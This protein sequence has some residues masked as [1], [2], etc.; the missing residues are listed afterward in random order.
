[1]MTRKKKS[2]GSGIE[3]IGVLHVKEDGAVEL[4]EGVTFPWLSTEP[5]GV[6]IDE[7]GMRVAAFMQR[8]LGADDLRGVAE[9]I[10]AIAPVIWAKHAYTQIRPMH[11]S[12]FDPEFGGFA[13]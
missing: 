9:A 3:C 13:E 11:L 8:R 10:A 2:E 12:E 1:M 4:A 5:M 7:R 6:E